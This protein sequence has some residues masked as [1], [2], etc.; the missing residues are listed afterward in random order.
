M[1]VWN[2]AHKKRLLLSMVLDLTARCNNNCSHC[3]INLPANDVAAKK[4]E[5]D[6]HDISAIMD[7]AQSLGTLWVLL[8]GG[9]PLLRPDF[10][11]IYQMLK[12]KGFFVSVFTNASLVTK[13]HI[14]LF[15]KYPPHN[16]EVSVYAA[17]PGVHQAVTRKNTFAQTMAGIDML[18]SAGLPVTLK[19]TIIKANA[20]ELDDIAAFCRAKSDRPFRFDP[21]LQLRIDNDH[22]KNKEIISQRLTPDDI[23]CMEKKDIERHQALAEKCTQKMASVNPDRLFRCQAGINSCAVGWDGTFRLCQSL[24]HPGTTLDLK[25]MTLYHAWNH[26]TP[27]VLETVSTDPAFIAN[28]PFPIRGQICFISFIRRIFQ[29]IVDAPDNADTAGLT[30]RFPTACPHFEGPQ[31]RNFLH[32]IIQRDT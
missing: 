26:F 24:V 2:Q 10:Y 11:D 1:P 28:T 16:I 8:S 14:A 22:E 19:S 6:S 12:K 30:P 4:Q 32:F 23:I 15:E 27:K 21:F 29:R 5:L 13:G 25:K 7:Q 18:V 31:P 3:Y 20:A 9:E 17:T